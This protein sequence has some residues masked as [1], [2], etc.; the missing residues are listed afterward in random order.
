MQDESENERQ[1]EEQLL[2]IEEYLS[3]RTVPTIVSYFIRNVFIPNTPPIPL[4]E[5]P[6]DNRS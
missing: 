3:L 2:P 1:F 5:P 6:P 4:L